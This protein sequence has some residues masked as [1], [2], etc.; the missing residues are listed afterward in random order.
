MNVS[1][2]SVFLIVLQ[3]T[4]SQE[5]LKDQKAGSDG[6]K[7][8]LQ[9]TR[10]RKTTVPLRSRTTVDASMYCGPE[11]FYPIISSW[12]MACSLA[13]WRDGP[14]LFLSAVLARTFTAQIMYSVPGTHVTIYLA[15]Q[16]ISIPGIYT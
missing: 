9:P 3:Y 6:S 8:D 16:A 5:T 13:S 4:K 7:Q 14:H 15:A 1:E 10:L 12:L 11:C 2:V